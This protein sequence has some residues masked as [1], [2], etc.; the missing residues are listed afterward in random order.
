MDSE[1][2]FERVIRFFETKGWNTS[3]T[4]VN[5]SVYIVT[6]TRQS[7]TYYDRMMAMVGLGPETTFGQTHVQYLVDAAADHDVDQLLATTRGGF[8]DGTEDLL[9]EH[10]IDVIDPETIDDAFIDGFE[11][12]PEPDTFEQA[13]ASGAGFLALG[14]D[15]FRHSFGSLLALYLVSGLLYGLIVGALGV[16]GT[17]T[18][19]MA[20]VLAG[21]LVLVGPVLALVGTLA[22]VA[23]RRVPSP[24]GLFFGSVFGYLLFVV[25]VG[26][27]GGLTGLTAST[28]LFGS[29]GE[30]LLV[31]ALGVPA[32]VGAIGVA[33][34]FVSLDTAET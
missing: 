9:A 17:A 13:A 34:A 24:A 18:G 2:Y 8:E 14:P 30:T 28:G 19:P 27:A 6:G 12:E 1:E 3:T 11:V 26:G 21:G 31:F 5:E 15:R 16:S 10:G 23:N 33:Y 7:D 4:Q 20:T 29:V 25:L 22:L 32:G